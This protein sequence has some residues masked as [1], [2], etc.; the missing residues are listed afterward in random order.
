MYEDNEI[1]YG[2]KYRV[3]KLEEDKYILFPISVEQGIETE[4]GFRTTKNKLIPYAYEVEDLDNSYVMDM[5]CTKDELQ[6]VYEYDGE[7][8]FL[9]DYFY[10]DF[11]NTLIF[12]DT[13]PKK[14]YMSRNEINLDIINSDNVD[15][16]YVM[17]KSLPSIVLNEAALDEILNCEDVYQ[18]RLLLSKYKQLI[19]TFQEF[20]SSKGVTKINVSNGKI[21]SVELKKKVKSDNQREQQEKSEDFS[22]IPIVSVKDLLERDISYRGLKHYLLERIFGHDE[23]I[24]T[25]AQKLYMNCTAEE[26]ETVESI[27]LV[28]PTGT[29]KTETVNAACEYLGLPYVENNASN[30]VPQGIKGICIEE[31]IAN[32]YE[33]A[34]Y[35]IEKTQRGLVFLDEFDKLNETDLE[36]KTS[37]KNILLTFTAGGNFPIDT[38]RFTFNFNSTMTNKVYAGV[39]DRITHQKR[40]IG[41]GR[42]IRE[43]E[44]L[45]TED[46]LREKIISK[47]YF[48][49]E[50]LSRISTLLPYSELDRETKKRILLKSK[51]SELAKKKNRY[52]RQFQID[53]IASD[54]Y[55]EAVLDSVPADATGMRS[56]NNIV[57]RN[58]NS[59]EQVLLES[60]HDGYKRLIL[61]RDTVENPRNFDL[62]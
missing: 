62:S 16:T 45:G 17:D 31:I 40:D 42:D 7:E 6:F 60:E 8:E 43:K 34:N 32:L 9:L 30:I 15:L 3:I 57:K 52:R 47:G 48:S 19:Q 54:D 55:I 29:G 2:I 20:N 61:T 5:I 44:S 24:T 28:G 50:E 12:I 1:E 36:L 18:V 53:L 26:G 35:D 58:I 59:A 14:G 22:S 46:E 37:V 25:F 4:D 27:L 13:D 51:L 56:V 41:F 49:L 10:D 21:E 11:K 23:A 33:R 39:F 38:D